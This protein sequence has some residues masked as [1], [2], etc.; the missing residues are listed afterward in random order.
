M[1]NNKVVLELLLLVCCYDQMNENA[2][3][4]QN[5]AQMVQMKKCQWR[6]YFVGRLREPTRDVKGQ[7]LWQGAI[8]MRWG[9][10]WCHWI[11]VRAGT[12]DKGPLV[13]ICGHRDPILARDGVLKQGRR[14]EEMF[15][16][17]SPLAFWSL[18]G[19]I[20]WLNSI[21]RQLPGNLGDIV[22]LLGHRGRQTRM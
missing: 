16:S 10:K 5:S 14:R 12:M 8:T 20:P 21:R 7:R 13:R 2:S 6:D 15:Q 4:K 9:D 1:A 17:L 19:P 22:C 11:A 18:A 3:K